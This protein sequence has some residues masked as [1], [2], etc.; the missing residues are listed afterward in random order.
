MRLFKDLLTFPGN[1]TILIQMDW[2]VVRPANFINYNQKVLKW[3]L[4]SI[5]RYGMYN[6][7]NRG[8]FSTNITKIIA[9]IK[10]FRGETRTKE[11]RPV[12]R[13]LL[14]QIVNQ[15]D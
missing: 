5:T 9:G 6:G 8:F 10:R 4:F 13:S 12:T 1:I 3:S 2:A 7:G 11:R 14:L 15:F